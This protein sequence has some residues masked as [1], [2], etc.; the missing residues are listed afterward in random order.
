MVFAVALPWTRR[1][2]VGRT[3]R[4]GRRQLRTLSVRLRNPY[5]QRCSSIAVATSTSTDG[6]NQSLVL[7]L[8]R[9]DARQ[10]ARCHDEFLFGLVEKALEVDANVGAGKAKTADGRQTFGRRIPTVE[11]FVDENAILRDDHYVKLLVVGVVQHL[12]VRARNET[13]AAHMEV[14]GGR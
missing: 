7:G 4:S 14:D 3:D 8:Q 11:R 1:T 6:R 10:T 9:F 12:K 5:F 13:T 2:T